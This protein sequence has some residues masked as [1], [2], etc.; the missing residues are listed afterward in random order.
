M[1]P[2]YIREKLDGTFVY[3]D[4]P[5]MIKSKEDLQRWFEHTDQVY[6]EENID[7]RSHLLS[8]IDNGL[9]KEQSEIKISILFPRCK[10]LAHAMFT[11]NECYRIS[12]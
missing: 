3:P 10:F 4:C 9:I 6:S 2:K 1:K 11:K 8:R 7:D 5:E 12:L